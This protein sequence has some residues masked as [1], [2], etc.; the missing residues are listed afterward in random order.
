VAYTA[1]TAGAGS[2]YDSSRQ[3]HPKG[4]P[5][6]RAQRLMRWRRL[7]PTWGWC[8]V[9]WLHRPAAWVRQTL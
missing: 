6:R 7:L 9:C 4:R 1:G 3:P 2:A 8:A 5:A